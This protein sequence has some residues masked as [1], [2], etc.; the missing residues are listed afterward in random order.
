MI[1]FAAISMIW[2][3]VHGKKNFTGPPVRQDADPTL[4][5]AVPEDGERQFGSEEEVKEIPK[6]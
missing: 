6:D 5:G 2:Y 3:F 4:Q 1:S